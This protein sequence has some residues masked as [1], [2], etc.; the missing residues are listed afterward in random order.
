M[1]L[2]KKQL[3][4]FIKLYKERYNKTLSNEEA[5]EKA[6]PFVLLIKIINDIEHK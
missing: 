4:S 5:L 3:N 1:G 2:T 6:I